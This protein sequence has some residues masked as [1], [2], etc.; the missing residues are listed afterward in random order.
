MREKM[1]LR[2]SQEIV[3]YFV[4]HGQTDWNLENRIQ[5]HAD[6]PLND[7][8]VAQVK[9]LKQKL[10]GIKF[11]RCF[12]SDLKRASETAQII[13][14]GQ[15]VRI[16]YD[17]RLRERNFGELEGKPSDAYINASSQDLAVVESDD[18]LSKRVFQFLSE[19]TGRN[20]Q[21]NILVVTHAG[22]IRTILQHVL[23]LRCRDI[24]IEI[25]NMAMMKLLFA[26]G[27]WEVGELVEIHW[28][29]L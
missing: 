5:G 17:K 23:Q 27:L 16:T 7:K 12:S 29:K 15:R 2:R 19:V 9:A 4:R 13:M 22:V 14:E 8:G 28:P 24:E 11:A 10:A 1:P 25:G 20:P 26:D 18:A 21:G 3:F 6:I